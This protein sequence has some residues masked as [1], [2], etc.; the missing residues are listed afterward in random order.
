MKIAFALV[1]LGS[2]LATNVT[3]AGWVRC[4][5]EDGY[6]HFQGSK[7]VRYGINHENRWSYL[8]LTGGAACNNATFG[9]PAYGIKKVCEYYEEPISS[10]NWQFCAIENGYCDFDG[11]K[12][13]RY[14]ANG[15]YNYKQIAD[16]IYCNNNT[17]GDPLVGIAKKCEIEVTQ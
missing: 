2:L 6:C 4:A 14:G 8:N 3:H 1:I 16:G 13:V 17:F 12:R 15:R 9:D 7:R 10:S 11:M 5:Q